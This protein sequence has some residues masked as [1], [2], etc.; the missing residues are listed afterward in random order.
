MVEKRSRNLR[1][2]EFPYSY[3]LYR[4]CRV[5]SE[6]FCLDSVQTAD[7]Y[8]RSIDHH[9]L[10][11]KHILVRLVFDVSLHPNLHGF[12]NLRAIILSGESFCLKRDLIRAQTICKGLRRSP[13]GKED[14]CIKS[15][16]IRIDRRSQRDEEAYQLH[17]TTMKWR[18]ERLLTHCSRVRG[19]RISTNLVSWEVRF[20]H[21]MRNTTSQIHLSLLRTKGDFEFCDARKLFLSSSQIKS[22]SILSCIALNRCGS[23]LA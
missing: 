22:Q 17:L 23:F 1:D 12:A 20:L 7:K 15:T 3:I 13:R 2:R 10:S 18:F 8:M 14:S 16:E 9:S 19:D 6:I 11:D 21:K 5:F 4:K